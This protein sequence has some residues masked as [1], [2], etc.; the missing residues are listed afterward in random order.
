MTN[1]DPESTVEDQVHEQP[2]TGE[3]ALYTDS[4]GSTAIDVRLEDDTVWLSQLQLSE[5][6]GKSVPTINEHLKKIFR[7]GELDAEATVRKF[8]IVRQEG[9]RTVN[10]DVDFYNL[11]AIISVGYRVSSQRA[12]Q[13]RQWATTVL[14]DHLIKGYTLNRR[15]LDA[16]RIDR[17]QQALALFPA[18][19]QQLA[20]RGDLNTD[21]SVALTPGHRLCR[22]LGAASPIRRW[23]TRDV[24]RLGRTGLCARHR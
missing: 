11:D 3:I 17:F 15:R 2:R 10:R 9:R 16:E 6:F 23:A 20:N 4:D 7:E 1:Q 14:R 8:R 13:F 21:E 24:S 19:V 5:L 12:T 22:K 18:T